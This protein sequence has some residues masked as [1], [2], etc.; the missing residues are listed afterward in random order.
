MCE[1]PKCRRGITL[2]ILILGAAGQIS[3]LVTEK[4]LTETNH[5]FV[6]LARNGSNR[7]KITEAN[8]EQIIDGDFTDINIVKKALEGIDAVYLNDLNSLAGVRTVVEA[9]ESCDVNILIVA[10]ILGIYGEVPG[11]WI[12]KEIQ[13][14][15]NKIRADAIK[16]SALI[17]AFYDCRCQISILR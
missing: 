7:I 11:V 5:S 10:S 17:L 9:M 16:H 15:P 3:R 1:L 4:L 2:K 8:R 14:Q 12:T 13:L 6:L